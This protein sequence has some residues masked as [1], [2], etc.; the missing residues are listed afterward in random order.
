MSQDERYLKA[1]QAGQAFEIATVEAVTGVHVDHFVEVNLIGFYYLAQAFGGIEVCVKPW[2][3]NDGANLRDQASGWD[4]LNDGYNL[5]KGG[6]SIC[7]LRHPRRLR[8]SGPATR[9]PGSTWA[10]PN[11]SR[12]WST[13][14]SGS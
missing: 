13:T 2:S 6:P 11:A 9:S 8:L 3:G 1:N 4:A 5:R 14:W 7:I 10:V 12:R